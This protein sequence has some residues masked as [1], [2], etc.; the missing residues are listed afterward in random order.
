VPKNVCIAGAR[1][2]SAMLGT[3]AEHRSLLT[4]SQAAASAVAMEMD[5][6]SLK[7]G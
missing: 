7:A 4:T 6:S 5:L 1:L 3:G 2:P